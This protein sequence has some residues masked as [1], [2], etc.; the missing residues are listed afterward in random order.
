MA[1]PKQSVRTLTGKLAPPFLFCAVMAAALF[2][3]GEAYR[4]LGAEALASTGSVFGSLLSAGAILSGAVLIQ[5][6][7]R[8]VLLEGVV[9]SALGEPV[10]RLLPQMSGL[11]IYVVAGG[12]I[13]GFVFHQDL[14]ALWAASG[15]GVVVF[16]MALR[17]MILDVF[18]GLAINLDRPIRIG[19]RIQVVR[20][21][22]PV[23]M[24]RVL[25]INWRSTRLYTEDA[26]MAVVP[27]SLIA[28]STIVNMSLPE[29]VLEFM[30][31]V[32][33]DFGV[34]PE[35]AMRILQAAATEA[36]A[37]FARSGAP[38]PYVRLR[39]VTPA[40]AEY[41][42]Y[43]YPPPE[44][45]YRARSATLTAA[46]RHLALA[47]IQPA[48]PKLERREESNAA[49]EEIGPEQL[50][51]L[52]AEHPLFNELDP[53]ALV[54]LASEGRRLRPTPG[55][56]TAQAGE[57]ASAFY[58]VLEGLWREHPGGALRGPGSVLGAEAMLGSGGYERTLAAATESVAVSFDHLAVAAMLACDDGLAARLAGRVAASSAAAGDDSA[59]DERRADIAADVLGALRRAYGLQTGGYFS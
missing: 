9:S 19:D 7:V 13:A 2:F 29:Q 8:Y 47:G 25:E 21:G 42:M 43:V 6:I 56:V 4:L 52:L 41:G 55:T 36:S 44:L 57:V 40:G 45:R 26:N 48:W 34:D 24:G 46:L 38:A 35:R 51:G 50:V 58:V 10:P 28:G 20:P 39:S 31:P 30:M 53:A 16:G 11:L 59:A 33:L 17:E 5:R 12:A 22:V 49:G 54:R 15:V 27:N 32:T 37:G 18:S 1:E 14:T 3:G 23:L